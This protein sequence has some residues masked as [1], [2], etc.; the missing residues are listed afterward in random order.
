MADTNA[1]L[2]QKAAEEAL[3]PNPKAYARPPQELR[4]E[5]AEMERQMQALDAKVIGRD[6]TPSEV[7]EEKRLR[8]EINRCRMLAE[9]IEVRL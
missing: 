5:I 7:A 4:Q 9:T 8:E 2:Y 6:R 3:V 1:D